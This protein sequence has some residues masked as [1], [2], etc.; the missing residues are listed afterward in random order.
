MADLFYSFGI[1]H[2]GRDA[3]H[4]YPKFLRDFQHARGNRLRHGHRSTSCA[5]VSA[6]CRATTSSA[7]SFRLNPVRDASTSSRDDAVGR[8]GASDGLRHDVETVDLMVGTSAERRPKGFGFSETAFRVFI[9]MASRRLKADRFFTDDY[10]PEIYTR[11]AS[12]GS[13]PTRWRRDAAPL[14]RAARR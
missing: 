2:P 9:L 1:P 4:N 10:R 7:G 12:T 3:L 11:R 5:T 13:T 14:P 6:A 8:R